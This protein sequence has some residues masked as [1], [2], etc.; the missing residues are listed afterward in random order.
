M[1]NIISLLKELC[2]KLIE[3]YNKKVNT[4]TL[5]YFIGQ[6]HTLTTEIIDAPSGSS[7][8]AVLVGN[9]VRIYFSVPD[10]YDIGAGNVANTVI[11]TCR[12]YTGTFFDGM[13]AATIN[14]GTAGGI[15]S[16]YLNN[17]TYNASG[18]FDFNIVVSATHQAFAGTNSYFMVPVELTM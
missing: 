2:N 1:V 18:Y 7:L 17:I 8:S 4:A 10:K 11:M 14:S 16:M 6:P 5:N 13:Y 15:T 9:C 3:I 12:I